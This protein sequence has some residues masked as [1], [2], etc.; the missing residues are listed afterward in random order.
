MLAAIAL[1]VFLQGNSG[2]LRGMFSGPYKWASLFAL[3]ALLSVAYAPQ[4]AFSLA[5]A[6]KLCLV[7]V[8][9]QAIS[10]QLLDLDDVS[11]FILATI[12]ACIFLVVAPS[13]R[14]IIPDADA[15]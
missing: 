15:T 2:S 1:L 7:V 3:V 10:K 5:W 11:S 13:F 14:S 4:I 8:V 6:F 9:L 12:A